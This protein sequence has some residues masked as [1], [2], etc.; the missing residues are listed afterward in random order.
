MAMIIIYHPQESLQLS[1]RTWY[2]EI[3]YRLNLIFHYIN[4]INTNDMTK[5]VNVWFSERELVYTMV[6][7]IFDKVSSTCLKCAKWSLLKLLYVIQVNKCKVR[8]SSKLL[9]M[10]FWNVRR[11]PEPECRSFWYKGLWDCDYRCTFLRIGMAIVSF[12]KFQSG[13]ILRITWDFFKDR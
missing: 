6:Q 7:T 3:I 2:W 9:S 4:A 1:S 5:K 10:N 11:V 13:E 8:H 12:L